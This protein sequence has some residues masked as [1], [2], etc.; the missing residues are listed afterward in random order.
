MMDKKKLLPFAFSALTLFLHGCGSESAKINEDP[1]DGNTATGSGSCS[2]ESEKCLEFA[3]DY[4]VAGL[5]FDCSSDTVHHFVTTENGNAVTGTCKLGDKV[6]FYLQGESSPNKIDLGTV[7]LDQV[8]KAPEAVKNG[9][10]PYIRVIDL[11]MGLTGKPPQSID[12]NDE[13]I[14]VAMSLVKI[15]Q[16]LGAEQNDNV[17]GDLQPTEITAEK[18]DLLSSI[19]KNIGVNEL[20]S[21]QYI[22][23]LEPWLAINSD[24]DTVDPVTG[25]SK[26]FTMLKQLL[27]L[28]NTGVWD[29]EPPAFIGIIDTGSVSLTNGFFGCNRDVYADCLKN[30]SNLLHSMGS[31]FLLTDRQGY[32]FGTGV[33]WRGNAKIQNDKVVPPYQYLTT[34]AK[35]IKTRIDAQNTWF[36]PITKQ[37]KSQHPLRVSVVDN[38]TSDLLINQGALLNNNII[39]GSEAIYKQAL[40]LKDKDSVNSSA[41]GKWTQTIDNT[42]YKG[43]LDIVKVSPSSYLS[44][45]IFKTQANVKSGQK[46]FF[47]LYGTLIFKF[48]DPNVTPKSISLGVV[49]DEY[50]DIRTDIKK[51]ATET[52]MSG[53]CLGI[54]KVNADGTIVD[55]DGVTQYRIGTTGGTLFSA[56]DSSMTVR[57]ILANSRFG[58]LD[59]ALIGL[60]LSIGKDDDEVG[61]RDT[62][63]KMI[64]HNLLAGSPRITLRD[65]SNNTASWSNI[66]ANK[67]S[68]YIRIYNDKDTDKTKYVKPTDEEIEMAKRWSGTVDITVADQNIAACQAVKTKA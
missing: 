57:I 47:P 27:N 50:G 64:V 66:Y 10:P 36:D 13:T 1:R 67:L 7:E 26:A 46:Y 58:M 35:P 31:F 8:Y 11:A 21:G 12:A 6:S 45:D 16:S 4:P 30:S 29:A 54:D 52:D 9:Q 65:F 42:T 49:I 59:G 22:E 25:D 41:L 38:A 23:I 68:T 56:N 34:T 53:N 17:I 62:N 63:A 44:K 28:S 40:Q 61:G 39:A 14:R 20:S 18:K 55:Q 37:V 60:N 32:T 48:N 2:V 19:T 24:L 3:L 33:Q 43:T 51:D 5:N 15:F